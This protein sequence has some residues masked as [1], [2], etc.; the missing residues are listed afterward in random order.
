MEEY[1]KCL[2]TN[3][4]LLDDEII[5]D[6][7]IALIHQEW[8]NDQGKIDIKFEHKLKK[9]LYLGNKNAIFK[10][11]EKIV[12]KFTMLSTD[13]KSSLDF[14]HTNYITNYG[15]IFNCDEE[16][17]DSLLFDINMYIP[18]KVIKLLTLNNFSDGLYQ[19]TC[20][21]H[22][23]TAYESYNC[24]HIHI[25]TINIFE[26]SKSFEKTIKMIMEMIK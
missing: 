11:N 14:M 25:N 26:N 24:N 4:S 19:S 23:I 3:N 5:L 22:T 18:E 17:N 13:Y 20:F 2:A 21:N 7:P 9:E 12:C 8:L 15:K 1:I 16:S 10:Q 6:V